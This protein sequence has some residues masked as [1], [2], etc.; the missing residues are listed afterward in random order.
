MSQLPTP[1]TSAVDEATPDAPVEIPRH[2]LVGDGDDRSRERRS[3]Q[4]RASGYRV[5][6]ARTGFETIVKACCHMPDLIVVDDSL[7]E[8]EVI[9]TAQLLAGCPVTAHIPVVR[10][11]S[12][13]RVPQRI[14]SRL[15]RAA[16]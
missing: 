3:S 15:Q 5:L 9:E 2:V 6:L 4:L 13:R 14:L 7:G 8:T 12:G 10:L 16:V 1:A 11:G